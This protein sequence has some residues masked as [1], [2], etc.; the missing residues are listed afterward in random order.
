[1]DKPSI[2]LV[3][4]V[5][6]YL[7]IFL[8]SLLFYMQIETTH[9]K[10]L[11]DYVLEGM[12]IAAWS[13]GTSGFHLTLVY[14][15]ILLILAIKLLH[16]YAVKRKVMT[17]PN[18]FGYFIVGLILI[19][20]LTGFAVY[21]IQSNADSLLSITYE[22]EDHNYSYTQENGELRSFSAQFTLRNQSSEAK[23]FHIAIYN[24]LSVEESDSI[25]QVLNKDGSKAKFTLM[26]KSKET[27][28]LDLDTYD[29][30]V[31]TDFSSSSG[32]LEQIVLTS[33][34]GE[35]VILSAYK[36]IGYLISK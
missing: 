11:G 20:M 14:F 26:G 24:S 7:S 23:I 16:T 22:D 5:K 25:I 1:M 30:D 31:K 21:T 2:R 17:G 36:T 3:D 12:G 28:V 8:V 4:R 6:A 27:Y 35:K 29:F 10:A 34:D 13:N 32:G 18:A 15:G 19:N 9:T 33:D